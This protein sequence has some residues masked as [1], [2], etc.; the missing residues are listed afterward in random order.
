MIS[1]HAASDQ[2]IHF[3]VFGQHELL[4]QLFDVNIW[5]T[6]LS[7]SEL[8]YSAAE[9]RQLQRSSRS[10]VSCLANMASALYSTLLAWKAF[11]TL[12]ILL[13]F[14][15]FFAKGIFTSSLPLFAPFLAHL[16][17]GVWATYYD[18]ICSTPQ[19]SGDSLCAVT[20]IVRALDIYSADLKL[21]TI[22]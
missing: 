12:K 20:R 2:M 9:R 4:C 13:S 14:Q 22:P 16:H 19:L 15:D 21:I 11:N 5:T 18:T 17:I 8:V 7:E 3:N 10:L 6:I 1:D